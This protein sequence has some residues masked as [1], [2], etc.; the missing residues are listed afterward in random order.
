MATIIKEGYKNKK[1]K[2]KR[3]NGRNSSYWWKDNLTM[4]Y[5]L[6]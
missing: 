6:N 3:R 1:E 5:F 2:S 4:K